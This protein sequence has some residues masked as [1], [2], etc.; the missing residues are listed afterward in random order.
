M[1]SK[2]VNTSLTLS[3]R[4]SLSYRNQ[5][6]DLQ[7]K[8]RDCFL[9]DRNLR[10]E[11]VKVLKSR[12][13]QIFGKF[14]TLSPQNLIWQMFFIPSVATVF[15]KCVTWGPGLWKIIR[16]WKASFSSETFYSNFLCMLQWPNRGSQ[17]YFEDGCYC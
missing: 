9:Y 6:I 10:Q 14:R 13:F 5:V 17:L 8:S 3:C 16:N 1:F 15:N 12:E 2:V 11:W 4:W 7:S